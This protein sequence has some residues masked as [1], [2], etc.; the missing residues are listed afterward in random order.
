MEPEHFIKATAQ[1]IADGMIY[2]D[3]TG[4]TKLRL[5][6]VHIYVDP[7]TGAAVK[8]LQKY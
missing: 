3:S 4:L 8:Y 6:T 2:Q 7:V 1:T 5:P